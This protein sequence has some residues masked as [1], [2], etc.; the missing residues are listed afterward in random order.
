[1]QLDRNKEMLLK[2]EEQTMQMKEMAHE[3]ADLRLQLHG[4][5]AGT[6]RH[7]LVLLIML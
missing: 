1:M 5:S 6:P 7:Y 4:T 3:L 2:Y